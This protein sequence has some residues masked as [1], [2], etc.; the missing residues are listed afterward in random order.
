[1]FTYLISGLTLG[2]IAGISPGPIL[3]LLITETIKYDK[4]AGIKIA[5][6]PFIS[7][8]PIVLFS[9]FVIYSLSNSKLILAILSFLGAVFLIYLAI[10]NIKIKSISINSGKGEIDGLVKAII[11]NFLSPHPYLF[12]ILVGAPITIKAYQNG[13][14]PAISFILSFY[15]VFF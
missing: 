8:L 15:V 13:I 5:F 14:A 12:W 6:V 10:E 9:F 7:D 2:I 11:A 3:I 1:M 4:K